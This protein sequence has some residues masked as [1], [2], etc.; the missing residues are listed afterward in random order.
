MKNKI[1]A[2]VIAS[3]CMAATL[4]SV[5]T[6]VNPFETTTV[7]ASTEKNGL[8]HEGSVW[9]YYIDNNVANGVTTLTKYNGSWWYVENGKINFNKT[10]LCKYNGSWWFVRGGR[11]DFNY[12]GLCKYNGSWWYV[13]N[14]KVDFNSRTLCKYNGIWWFINGGRVDFGSRT[15]VKYGNTWY[16]VSGG[17][18]HWNDSGLCKYND[19][20]W[21]IRNGK[22]DFGARTLCKYNGTWW[23]VENG[24]VNF[25]PT[26]TLVYYNGTWW[27]VISGQVDWKHYVFN[28]PAVSYNGY[29]YVCQ[30]GQVYWG[31]APKKLDTSVYKY[32]TNH[33]RKEYSESFGDYIYVCADGSRLDE[34]DAK[35]G[36]RDCGKYLLACG[37]WTQ[38]EYDSYFG[39]NGT[40][41]P[42]VGYTNQGKPYYYDAERDY[43]YSTTADGYGCTFDKNGQCLDFGHENENYL[44]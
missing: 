8:Y 7:E 20:W 39:Y 34:W 28:A 33:I 27:N 24:K 37:R 30:D 21:Y 12:N 13:H 43:Y 44:K 41:P 32:D 38:D 26:R 29:E 6:Y 3:I 22:I 19:N 1:R 4:S 40:Y 9:N 14:G 25:S 16:Y 18:V 36:D 11:V 5:P 42:I 35:A 17:Q 23:F 2:L 15:V 31:V 10:T